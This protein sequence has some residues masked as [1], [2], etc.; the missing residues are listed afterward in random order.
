[1]TLVKKQRSTRVHNGF[2]TIVLSP[3]PSTLLPPT[4]PHHINTNFVAA[5]S[6]KLRLAKYVLSENQKEEEE[7]LGTG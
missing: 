4:S 2:R 6:G 7:Y 5:A 1:M 3:P